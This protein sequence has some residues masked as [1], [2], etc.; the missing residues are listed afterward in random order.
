MHRAFTLIE[1]LVVIS[2]V[3]LLIAILLPALAK[4]RDAAKT[5]QCLANLRQIGV[6]TQVYAVSNDG[7]LMGYQKHET[8]MISRQ[9][10]PRRRHLGTLLE[11]GILDPNTNQPSILYCPL[12]DF[13][14]SWNQAQITRSDTQTNKKLYG[15][16]HDVGTSY[17]TNELIAASYFGKIDNTFDQWPGHIVD[18]LPSNFGIAYDHAPKSNSSRLP[19]HGETYNFLNVDGS[20][21]TWRDPDNLVYNRNNNWIN[22]SL[23]KSRIAQNTNGTKVNVRGGEGLLEIFNGQ[24]D[25]YLLP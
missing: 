6:S 14:R 1:L 24:L 16:R 15:N 20:A 8:N 17:E 18:L 25:P 10:D 23:A 22:S 12:D 9:S 11:E 2:I 21:H 3:S 19:W 7:Y 5:S 13:Y 4:A